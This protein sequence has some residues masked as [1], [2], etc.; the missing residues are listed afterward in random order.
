MEGGEDHFTFSHFDDCPKKVV[1]SFLFFQNMLD[2]KVEIGKSL[3]FY[4]NPH[5]GLIIAT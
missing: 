1:A 5:G 3:S 2:K 4:P